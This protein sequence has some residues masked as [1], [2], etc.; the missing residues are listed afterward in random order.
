MLFREIPGHEI[1]KK[2]LRHTVSE[3]RISH[4]QLFHGPEGCGKLALALAYTQYICCTD[5]SEMDSCGKCPS[6]T[7]L[8]KHIHPDVHFVYPAVT[9]KIEADDEDSDNAPA[10]NFIEKWR[11]ALIENPYL[12]QFQWYEKIGIETKQGFISAKDSSG[13][14]R[15]LSLKSYESDYKFLIMWLPERMHPTAANRLLK[16]I[17][18]PPPLTLF[19][20]ISENY[21]EILPTILSRTQ[22]LRIPAFKDEDIRKVLLEKHNVIPEKAEDIVRLANGNYNKALIYLEPDLSVKDNFERFVMLTRSCFARN[23]NAILS[24]VESISDIGREKQKLFLLYAIRMIRENYILNLGRNEMTHM[25]SYENEFSINFSKFIH[26]QN[27]QQLSEELNHA[28]NHISANGY[29]RIVFM[30]MCM[31]FVNLLK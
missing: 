27:I 14:I 20:L 15:K 26:D 17:E 25:T 7:K 5:K 24:W 3:G 23:L 21:N 22:M 30:D 6:C 31:K 2:R 10:V 16:I 18:E 19:L 9:T 29:A 12:N 8:N 13:I 28:Y 4:A 11:E 1:I